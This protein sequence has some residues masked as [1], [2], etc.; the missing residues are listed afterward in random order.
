MEREENALISYGILKKCPGGKD[1]YGLK[2][3]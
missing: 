1:A 3:L 2:M